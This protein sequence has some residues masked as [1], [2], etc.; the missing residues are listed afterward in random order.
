[1][2]ALDTQLLMRQQNAKHFSS[3]VEQ[4]PSSKSSDI[5]DIR[6]SIDRQYTDGKG[7][8]VKAH[9]CFQQAKTLVRLHLG[10]IKS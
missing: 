9:H 7:S 4:E 10:S 1:M 3:A 8:K 6:C 5:T 2:I